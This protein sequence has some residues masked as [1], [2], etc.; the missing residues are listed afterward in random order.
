MRVRSR[1]GAIVLPVR[2]DDTVRPGHAFLPMHWGSAYMGGHGVN[3]LTNPA[4]DP[5]SRQPELK[6]AAVAVE[7]A[8]LPWQAMAWIAGDTAVL[9][10]QLAP[11]LR[12]FE[13]AALLPCAAGPG[14]RLRLAAAAP[15][16]SH[17][18]DALA[19]ALRL[20]RPHAAFDDV[21]RGIVRRVR[22]AGDAPGADAP[23]AF[24]LAGDVRAH[25]GLMAWA[26]GGAAPASLAT[27]LMARGPA[28][29]RPRTICACVGISE[30]AI[31]SGIEA[32]MDVAQL[33]DRLGCGSGCG[34]CL[35]EVRRMVAL[36]G[37]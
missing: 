18:V 7:P 9:R 26:E 14:V 5:V 11:W 24:M 28:A 20:D 29:P 23:G 6:H 30:D 4:R 10:A 16:P 15:A 33:K 35:P 2:P 34:S 17:V 32:G 22:L 3:A 12:G 1:R 31:R 13:Y 19:Q 21:S 8:R 37:A 36:H 27:L 25:D